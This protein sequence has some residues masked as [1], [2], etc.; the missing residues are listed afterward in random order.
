[1]LPRV[2]TNASPA[3]DF[4]T[5]PAGGHVGFISGAVPWRTESWAEELVVRWLIEQAAAS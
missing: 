3:V 5:T 2:R 1:M 4:R